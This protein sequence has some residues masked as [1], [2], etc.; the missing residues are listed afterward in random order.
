M[1]VLQSAYWLELHKC[2]SWLSNCVSASGPLY[3]SS[4]D[5]IC[6]LRTT[7]VKWLSQPVS[8][9]DY[10]TGC[11]TSRSRIHRF[12]NRLFKMQN[13]IN[14]TNGQP[15]SKRFAGVWRFKF[16]IQRKR[17]EN[18]L[19]LLL[20]LLH[21]NALQVPVVFSNHLYIEG[22]DMLLER[23]EGVNV[24]CHKPATCTHS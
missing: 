8:S 17:N 16:C 14:C 18:F 20:Y 2:Q 7:N 5:S 13:A 23:W 15:F 10:L 12:L 6:V 9:T 19:C 24:L 3:S 1:Q 21:Q 22:W 11:I 4:V